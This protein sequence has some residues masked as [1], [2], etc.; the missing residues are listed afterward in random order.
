MLEFYLLVSLIVSVFLFCAETLITIYFPYK[1]IK[2]KYIVNSIFCAIIM[3]SIMS[4][5][6]YLSTIEIYEITIFKVEEIDIN[7]I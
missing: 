3:F 7:N 4:Y 2:T 1:N 5:T 6:M